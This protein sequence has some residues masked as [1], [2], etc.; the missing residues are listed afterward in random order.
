MAEE[1][2]EQ[3]EGIVGPQRPSRRDP[4]GEE[5]NSVTRPIPVVIERPEGC[6]IDVLLWAGRLEL[7]MKPN[8]IKTWRE[9]ADLSD[10]KSDLA[11][12]M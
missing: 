7:Q 12:R 5:P 8:V 1:L 4:G 6:P 9:S 11:M 2:A 3:G 10:R